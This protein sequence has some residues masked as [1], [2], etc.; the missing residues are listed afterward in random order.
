[1]TEEQSGMADA[2]YPRQY[3]GMLEYYTDVPPKP[4]RQ[5]LTPKKAALK[6]VDDLLG[7]DKAQSKPAAAVLNAAR[8]DVE[9]LGEDATKEAIVEALGLY[10]I[11]APSLS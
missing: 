3:S 4:K 2:M 5:M 11:I 9:A 7:E 8:A 6:H 10:Q 1:M